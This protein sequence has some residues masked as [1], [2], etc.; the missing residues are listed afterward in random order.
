M[1]KYLIDQAAALL[2]QARRDMAPLSGLPDGLKPATVDD[3]HAI[4]DAVSQS[5]GKLIGGFK[6]MAPPNQQ[7][8]RGIIYADTIHLS[9]CDLPART[10]PQCGVEGEVAFVFRESLPDRA[11]PYS[12]NEVAAV[13]DA[14][15]AIEVVHSRYDIAKPL[16]NLEKLADSIMNGGL[17]CAAPNPNWRSLD[18]E[19][20]KVTM[21]VNRKVV[22]DKTGGHPLGDPLAVAVAMANMWRPKGGVRAGQV[23]T[24]G[25]YTGL[26]YL[27]PGD[28]CKVT[29][30]GLGTATVKFTVPN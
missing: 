21:T 23:V 19:N 22:K 16:S 4:Q 26:D 13:V 8:N 10:V 9:P 11:V 15:A 20:I 27:K 29:F 14:F 30:E 2:V 25:S 6:A 17:V 18:L 3:G 24:C 28:T 7:P 12:R 5:L 1:D